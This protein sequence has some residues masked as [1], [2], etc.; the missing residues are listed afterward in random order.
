MAF[1]LSPDLRAALESAS[2]RTPSFTMR[3]KYK[4]CK[5]TDVLR[6]DTLTAAMVCDEN[7]HQFLLKI[8][9]VGC[10]PNIHES[11]DVRNRAMAKIK[12][13]TL[14]RLASILCYF[15]TMNNELV[16]SV[17]LEDGTDLGKTL[18]EMNLVPH[19]KQTADIFYHPPD[20]FHPMMVHPSPSPAFTGHFP[21][22]PYVHPTRYSNPMEYPPSH[23]NYPQSIYQEEDELPIPD[24]VVDTPEYSEIDC[25]DETDET[26]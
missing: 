1:S 12:E 24:I 18:L 4:F 13:L 17:R 16:C 3:G 10:Y 20:S 6:E 11:L 5:I 2:D 15:H 25:R 19:F 14:N 23:P 9:G 26:S 8:K 21:S 7:I 22:Q